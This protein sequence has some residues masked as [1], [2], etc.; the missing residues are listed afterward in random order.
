[1]AHEPV[2]HRAAAPVLIDDVHRRPYTESDAI[3][4]DPVDPVPFLEAG[5]LLGDLSVE[6]LDAL[7]AT[8]AGLFAAIPAVY[9]YNHLASR[10]KVL[11]TEMDD[12]SLEFLTIAERN[13]T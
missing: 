13:F 3:H 6:S 11:A 1:M 12:F 10:V 8:A 7:I 5:G 2:T 9:F 4:Q